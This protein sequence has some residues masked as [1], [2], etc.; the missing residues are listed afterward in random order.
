MVQTKNTIDKKYASQQNVLITVSGRVQG[1][2]F[3]FF[4]YQQAKKLNLNGYVA[5]LVNG[6]VEIMATGSADNIAQLITWL[7]Q[8]GPASAKITTYTIKDIEAKNESN[9]FTVRY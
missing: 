7:E 4:T 9:S 5:N 8:G 6:D 2:G 1:V 3:R